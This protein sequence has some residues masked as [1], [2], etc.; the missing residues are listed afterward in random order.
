[1]SIIY[2]DEPHIKDGVYQVVYHSHYFTNKFGRNLI[3]LRFQLAEMNEE[4]KY[5][6]FCM[7][8]NIKHFS[9]KTKGQIR[10]NVSKRQ[11]FAFMWLKLFP[12]QKNIRLDRLSINQLKGMILKATI[13]ASKKDFEQNVIPE[14][15]RVSK[16]IDLSLP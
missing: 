10:W 6:L 11:D 8:K 3:V 15:L 9:K 1:M 7:W 2:D 4:Y 14:P 13:K 5:S 16:I 12:T